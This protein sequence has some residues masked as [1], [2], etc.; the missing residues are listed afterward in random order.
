MRAIWFQSLL[1]SIASTYRYDPSGQE[2]ALEPTVISYLDPVRQRDS[3]PSV[4]SI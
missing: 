1:L 4:L 2:A 3:D